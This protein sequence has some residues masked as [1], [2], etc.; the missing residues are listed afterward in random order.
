MSVGIA[1]KLKLI[2]GS[3]TTEP[4]TTNK[5]IVQAAVQV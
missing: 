3:L 2:A 5:N 4:M 1:C